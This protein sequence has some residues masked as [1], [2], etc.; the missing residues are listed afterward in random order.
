MLRLV[1]GLICLL[2]ALAT[3]ATTGAIAQAPSVKIGL[4]LPYTGVLSVAG[5]DATNGLSL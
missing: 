5:I 4:L 3:S 2:L 1:S